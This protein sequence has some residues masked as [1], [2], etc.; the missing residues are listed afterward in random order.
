[1]IKLLRPEI[2]VY[3][4]PDAIVFKK[5]D[6]KQ[7]IYDQLKERVLEE[8]TVSFFT[9]KALL[10]GGRKSSD[11]CYYV[12]NGVS[13]ETFLQKKYEKTRI[14]KKCSEKI[15]GVVGT[16]DERI[17]L[18][19]IVY[20]LENIRESILFLVGPVKMKMG[21]LTH[22]PRVVLTGQRAYEEMP[23]FINHF[24][25]GLIPYR[26]NEVTKAIYPVKLHEYLILGKPVVSTDLPE[27]RQFSDLVWIAGSR[28]R[29]VW[30]IRKALEDSN[31][32]RKAKRIEIAKRN[33]W[34]KRLDQIEKIIVK[35]Y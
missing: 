31:A 15:L 1:M 7:K 17:D 20:V 9:S 16:V 13:F 27:V 30:C 35:Y 3:D 22:H 26:I 6:W 32:I 4:C 25:V 19:L 11:H 14:I 29:F 21:N 10:K 28:E 24:D 18:D 23:S 34:E 33:S 5:N 12:P 8:S 2:A